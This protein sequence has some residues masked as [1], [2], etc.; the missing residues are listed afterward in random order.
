[1][2][3]PRRST[4]IVARTSDD[5]GG[6]SPGLFT[7]DFLAAP[8]WGEAVP[9]PPALPRLLPE[10]ADVVVIGSGYTGLNA[11]LET[12]RGGRSTVVLEAGDPGWGCSTRNGGQVSSSIKPSLAELSRRL[13]SERARRIRAEGPA[14]LDWLEDFLQAEGIDC[15]FAR[16]GKVLAAHTPAAYETLA[17]KA[18]Q[19]MRDEGIEAHALP[20]DAQRTEIDTAFYHGGVV[21]PTFA[22]LHPARYHRGLLMTALASG[23]QVV[24][25]CAAVSVERQRD[26]FEVTTELGTIR[27]RAVA[28]ATNGYTAG[29]TPWLQRRV[30]PIGSYVIATEPLAP[31]TV[32]R[33]FP[34]GR[35]VSDT[36]RVVYY[37]GPSP[38]GTRLVFG[39]RVSSGETDPRLSGPRLHADMVRIFP[40]LATARISHSWNGFVAYTFDHLA[41]CGV[42]DG[43]HYAM[44]YCGS[45]VGMASY[46][47][48]RM[49]QRIL[50]RAEGQ[51]AFDDLPFPTRPLYAG[52]PWFLPA[53][54]AWYRWRDRQECRR[55][56][57]LTTA[58]AA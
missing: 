23:V 7:E 56:A 24:P 43:M 15:A 46:L 11:A 3:E 13:G 10:R 1:M 48:M 44:G 2:T 52:R 12:V 22:R 18:E 37:Y 14:A 57:R 53:T 19:T 51:T 40:E 5:P 42:Q 32:E 58:G 27:A 20:R 9:P 31:G 47:G 54:V 33:L 6:A 39:G 8:Y 55:A 28:V 21:Y 41:H 35:I 30:I 50:G 17:R 16:V 49:G 4:R 45:G 38:D 36:R 26:G 29:L 25:H 34:R